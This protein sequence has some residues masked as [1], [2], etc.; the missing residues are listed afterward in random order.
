M[1]AD[2]SERVPFPD[3][4]RIG[5]WLLQPSIDRLSR[6]GTVVHL[7][8]Q[9][10]NLLVLLTQHAG[11]T[12]S[13]DE[14]L[15]KVWEGQFVAESGMTRCIAEIRQALGDDAR[16]PKIVQTIT[17]R[18]YRL[19]APVARVE[20]P[21]P[22]EPA[23]VPSPV[24]TVDSP[25]RE[26][27]G[28]RHEEG[29]GLAPSVDKT[30]A[31]AD[32]RQDPR[33]DDD[34]GRRTVA[35][36]TR[37]D[38]IG[39][40]SAAG[41]K[42]RRWRTWRA[43][44][45]TVASGLVLLALTW[46]AASL[47][48]VPI[49][50]ERDTVLLADV[51]NTTGDAAFDQTLRLALA[52]QLGQAPF[53]RILPD[54]RVRASLGLMGRPPQQPVVGGVALEL[55]RREGAA[56]LLAGS[57]SKL[58]THYAVGLEAIACASGESVG[59]ELIEVPGKNE[60]LAA[61]G[62]AAGRLRR[63]LG[64]S[65]ESLS[66]YDVPIA[67]AT[68]PSLD[69]LKALS[70][71][72]VERDRARTSEALMYF[73]R[74]TDLDPQFALAWARRGAAAH[75]LARAAGDE[76]SGEFAE[77]KMSFQKAFALR[78]RVSEPERFYIL[79]HYYRS[80][81][82]DPDK[83]LETYSLW[84][85]MYPG[86]SIPSINSASIRANLFGQ[87]DAALADARE[88]VRLA[89]N[90]ATSNLT[91]VGTY[92][93]TNRLPE[94][95]LALRDATMRGVDNLEWHRLA[96]EMAIVDRDEAAVQ[97][98]IRWASSDPTA[99]MVIAGLRALASASAGRM[100]EARQF[101]SEAAKVAAAV[102]TPAARSSILLAQAEAEAL[103][104]DP[105]LAREAADVAAA[106]DPRE[107]TKLS[108]ASSLAL[109]GDAARAD[110]MLAD[111]PRHSEPDTMTNYVWEPVA[112]ALAAV[113]AGRHDQ[114]VQ[115]LGGTARFERGRYFRLVPL[116]VRASLEQ[117]TGHGQAA[118]AAFAELLR[119][120]WVAPTS[121]W[122]AFARL[123]LARALRDAGDLAGSRAAY[124]AAVESM[125]DGDQDA[126]ILVAARRERR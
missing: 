111:L 117:S 44:L 10:T 65:R 35:A 2:S 7:R 48:P 70:L 60:V 52:V 9:L 77:A 39:P 51:D 121:P 63:R 4:V 76:R 32:G 115:F 122:V 123:G 49:L 30:A 66:K 74:A 71:G 86:S 43:V 55:C 100:R 6:N 72:D 126:P 101:W 20:Q 113:A 23:S 42:P 22:V 45:V 84:S 62:T 88:G 53:L 92:L 24:E 118:A 40:P 107:S 75:N 78:D 82:G 119:L 120:Q 33:D 90:S 91:L 103:L 21:G 61:L 18:G 19:M 17:K 98:H 47:S 15:S 50:S 83:A 95:R 64:E 57:I 116:G 96:F 27:R 11:R 114:A 112:R 79:A 58:G 31:T 41:S 105:R 46:G 87:Y 1:V 104:G 68:T 106:I 34:G 28:R 16:D 12:V 37:A 99:T 13:K 89:P 97:E 81:L 14:I 69:A 102:G 3:D 94:A 36:E 5:D 110:R 8:P 54:T 29:H 59:R 25:E 109:V 80:V 38:E 125:K 67:R 93:G 85:R 73:R 56:L 108:A 124:D 26:H